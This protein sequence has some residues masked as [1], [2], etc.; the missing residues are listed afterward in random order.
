MKPFLALICLTALVSCDLEAIKEQQ[1]AKK[2]SEID[3]L[4][5]AA[6]ALPVSKPCENRDAYEALRAAESNMGT[7]YYTDVADAKI[8]RYA[9]ACSDKDFDFKYLFCDNTN[10][11]KGVYK[12]LENGKIYLTLAYDQEGELNWDRSTGMFFAVARP[13]TQRFIV[14]E[15]VHVTSIGEHRG[16]FT[17]S[18]EMTSGGWLAEVAINRKSLMMLTLHGT[19]TN[20]YRDD[21]FTGTCEVSDKSIYDRETKRLLKEAKQHNAIFEQYLKD[22]EAKDRESNII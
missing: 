10:D 6:R 3:T 11:G 1:M 18:Y 15:D 8:A 5:E 21:S 12:T 9:Q 2:K 4:Y 13:T 19:Y 14:D 20:G 16:E 7:S 17:I 22:T